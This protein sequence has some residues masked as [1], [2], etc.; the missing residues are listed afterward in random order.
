MSGNSVGFVNPSSFLANG[1]KFSED[2]NSVNAGFDAVTPSAGGSITTSVP[3]ELSGNG[4]LLPGSAQQNIV[5]DTNSAGT[6]DKGGMSF[7]NFETASG[8]PA[9]HDATGKATGASTTEFS[10][11]AGKGGEDEGL[12]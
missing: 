2:A 1:G 5:T 4:F 3:A 11:P 9:G 10:M 8:A 6:S 12:A 7:T